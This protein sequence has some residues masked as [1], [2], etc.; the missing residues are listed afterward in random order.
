VSIGTFGAQSAGMSSV[1]PPPRGRSPLLESV[2]AALVLR[3]YSPKTVEAYV[4]W[5]RR[6]VLFHQCQH[7]KAM[8]EPEVSA[9]LSDLATRVGVSASTQNQALAALLFLY[10]EIVH[11]PLAPV[12]EVVHAKRPGRLPVVMS[13]AEVDAVL[14]QLDGV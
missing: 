7:P 10:A 8:G 2:G 4:G 13:R 14:F 5:V 12:S 9:F 1:A 6:F 11:Q 3:H